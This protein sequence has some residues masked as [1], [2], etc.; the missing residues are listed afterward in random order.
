MLRC[1]TLLGILSLTLL[2]I[3]LIPV[4]T[5]ISAPA[6]VVFANPQRIM[7]PRDGRF[8]AQLT[9]GDRV[10]PGE[11]VGRIESRELELRK[12]DA[13][14]KLMEIRLEKELL[15]N[16]LKY[17]DSVAARIE[18]LIAEERNAQQQLA[19]LEQEISSLVL[20]ADRSGVVTE[21]L[22]DKVSHGQ[23]DKT[24]GNGK[25]MSE[26]NVGCWVAAGQLLC[27]V[28]SPEDLR[29][30]LLL[31]EPDLDLIPR[32]ATVRV[33]LHNAPTETL[34]G[35]M[36]RLGYQPVE[37]VPPAFL[38]DA[39]IPALP[40]AEGQYRPSENYFYGEASFVDFPPP[41]TYRSPGRAKIE[42]AR[43]TIGQRLL[44]TLSQIFFMTP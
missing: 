41:A 19:S 24:A 9:Y 4:P 1:A 37:F 20:Y 6:I 16:E 18:T 43:R 40:T 35:V 30:L 22:E 3:C 26:E 13:T 29:L 42:I 36:D 32:M 10:E 12:L 33:S 44:R 27:E 15:S 5:T 21:P 38:V 2:G 28:G 8:F 39:S 23:K 17:S 11:I 7:A 14:A 34:T 31:A 25:P